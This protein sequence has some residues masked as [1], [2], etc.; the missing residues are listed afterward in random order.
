MKSL[1][2]QLGFGVM[3]PLTRQS[4]GRSQ[5]GAEVE[6]GKAG[7]AFPAGVQ[8]GIHRV[9]ISGRLA[10]LIRVTD[11]GHHEKN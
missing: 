7:A 8:V 9:G 4:I 1:P 11:R 3:R 2:A 10:G 5:W 6:E